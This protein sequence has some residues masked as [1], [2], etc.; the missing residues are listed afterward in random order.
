MVPEIIVRIAASAAWR[1]QASLHKVGLPTAD[2]VQ[3]AILGLLTARIDEPIFP[4]AYRKKIARNKVVSA[5]RKEAPHHRH[6]DEDF[7][8]HGELSESVGHDSR[9]LDFS[10]SFSRVVAAL[11]AT[12]RIILDL[13]LKGFTQA[14]I[15]REVRMRKATVSRRCRELRERFGDALATDE[16]VS[17]V[18]AADAAGGVSSRRPALGFRRR[19]L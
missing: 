1:Y 16:A 7:F 10:V 18:P 11:D 13:R 9:A 8:A 19:K 6:R 17:G 14:E 15:G 2:A 12:D 4:M 5:I 3:D